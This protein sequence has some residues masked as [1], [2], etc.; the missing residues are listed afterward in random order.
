[1]VDLS[2]IVTTH[3]ERFYLRKLLEQMLPSLRAN[4]EVI[5]I[6][7][8]ST[9][10]SQLL[11]EKWAHLDGKFRYVWTRNRGL[12][13]ARNLGIDLM[14]GRFGV[15]LDVDDELDLGKLWTNVARDALSDNL[16]FA[17]FQSESYAAKRRLKARAGE[18]NRYFLKS[19][20]VTES[21]V[22]GHRLATSLV[23][24]KSYSVP[25]WQYVWRRSFLKDEHIRFEEGVLM[26]DNLFTFLIMT[27]AQ[28]SRFVRSLVHRRLIRDGSIMVDGSAMR[29]FEGY[30]SAF[31]R[32]VELTSTEVGQ[33]QAW[34]EEVIQGVRWQLSRTSRTLPASSIQ[35]ALSDAR[36]E[37]ELAG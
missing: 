34:Q 31:I 6:D 22:T 30:L 23:S 32:M 5:V 20:K 37:C 9:D 29:H 25:A 14:M 35:R 10:G 11:A 3:N 12:G 21:T 33:R 28:K 7:D 18:A 15:F 19:S 24:E 16:D 2:I 13:A 17:M 27:R 26:E 1:M 8:G 4:M 36:M